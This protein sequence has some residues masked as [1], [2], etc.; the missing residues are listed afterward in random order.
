MTPLDFLNLLWQQPK[1]TY[2]L[3]WTGQDKNSHA[4]S[5]PKERTMTLALCQALGMRVA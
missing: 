4:S 5:L 1:V 3:I 2:D